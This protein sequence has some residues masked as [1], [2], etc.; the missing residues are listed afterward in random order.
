VKLTSDQYGSPQTE[1]VPAVV[2]WVAYVIGGVWAQEMSGGRDFLSPGLLVCLQVRQ[3]WQGLG[4]AVLWIF[5]HEG[6]GNLA[7]GAS[8]LFYVGLLILFFASQWFLEPENPLFIVCFS[9]CLSGWL[10]AVLAGAVSLQELSVRLPE[11]WPWIATQWGVYAVT[12]AFSLFVYR[13]VV[14]HGRV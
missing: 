3:W 5:L 7:F 11:P 10:Y 13:R 14:R 2:W 4:V 1:F 8:L 6:G 12:W 9:L